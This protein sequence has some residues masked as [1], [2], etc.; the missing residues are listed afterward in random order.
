MF[1]HLGGDT[2]VLKSDVI[3]ILDYKKGFSNITKEFI[4]IAGEEGFIETISDPGK[5]KSYVITSEKIFISP[6]SCNTLKK[7][8]MS[9]LSID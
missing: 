4:E 2:V 8:S 9:R 7:R 5:E 3:A 1:L 6:I